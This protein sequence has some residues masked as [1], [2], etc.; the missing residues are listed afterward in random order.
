MALSL[1]DH[2]LW[3]HWVLDDG[4]RYH[5]FFL[6]ASR[7]LHDPDRRHRRASLGHAVSDD[8]RHWTLLP[9]ALVH[10]DPP[11][12]DDLAVWTGSTVLAPDGRMRVFYTGISRGEDGAV[13]RIGWADSDDGRTFHRT[14]AEPL[15]A[16]PRWYS[17]LG[18]DGATEEHWRDPFV[19]EHEGQWHMLITARA[20]GVQV[21]CSGVVAH[22]VS[23][24]LDHWRVCEPLTAPSVF[25][26]LEV[27]Q[28]RTVDG[29]HYLVFSCGRDVQ[30]QPCP[31]TV[32][33]AE[34]Q[35]PLGPWD[36]DGARYVEPTHL[37]GGQ[38]F[39]LR[40]GGWA[41]TAFDDRRDG[42]FQGVA[43]DPIAW[44]EV[45]LTARP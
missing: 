26:Q 19:F 23:E 17:T 39:A 42:V 3:D 14:C 34:G 2:W 11:A 9:D 21:L 7:A 38:L 35:G 12:W 43:P 20:R 29:H 1:P 32:W 13:Q 30:A 24:D 44:E 8:A 31:G 33:V 40:D 18:D 45:V 37:Y 4:S 6:R 22:A 36:V 25:G 15:E 28:S 10:S 27:S 5:L 16:D 41:L